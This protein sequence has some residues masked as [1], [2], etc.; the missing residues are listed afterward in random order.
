[1]GYLSIKNFNS[2]TY[3]H[4]STDKGQ[5]GS[6]YHVGIGC[7]DGALGVVDVRNLDR[8]FAHEFRAPEA[9]SSVMD[10]TWSDDGHLLVGS[11][12]GGLVGGLFGTAGNATWFSSDVSNRRRLLASQ[13]LRD[14]SQDVYICHAS[15]VNWNTIAY[16][17]TLGAVGALRL[18]S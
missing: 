2:Q 14:Q 7:G 10:V 4:I 3:T 17:D 12:V 13:D 16:S 5:S 1:M 18:S 11:G 9:C 6:P 8:G 15:A